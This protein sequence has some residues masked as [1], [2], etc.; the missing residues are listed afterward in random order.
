MFS[1]SSMSAC[2]GLSKEMKN[3][4]FLE[5]KQKFLL[6]SL[7][8]E[9][10]SFGLF[11]ELQNTVACTSCQKQSFFVRIIEKYKKKDTLV[12]SDKDEI[13][14][15]CYCVICYVDRFCN[16]HIFQNHDG[17]ETHYIFKE[18]GSSGN[19]LYQSSSKIERIVSSSSE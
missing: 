13:V 15:E 5:H 12:T 11:K 14:P 19:I 4:D 7:L 2:C 8:P 1:F 18:K 10:S 9:S 16:I 3:P 17:S 6:S